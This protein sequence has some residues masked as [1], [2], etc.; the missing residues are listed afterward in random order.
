MEKATASVGWYRHSPT[1]GVVTYSA[2]R[3]IRTKANF[4]QVGITHGRLYRMSF[5][6]AQ[7]GITYAQLYRMLFYAAQV[8]ITYVN[9][10]RMLFYES[11]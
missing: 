8:G 4:V 2:S 10:H 11:F 9:L 6:V 5:Y 1:C 7:I 3:K